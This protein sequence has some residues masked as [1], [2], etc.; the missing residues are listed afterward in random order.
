M[1]QRVTRA[2]RDRSLN[3][4]RLKGVLKK[5]CHFLISVIIAVALLACNVGVA[6]TFCGVFFPYDPA[7]RLSYAIGLVIFLAFDA[8]LIVVVCKLPD[9]GEGGY[10][11]ENDDD[12]DP[13]PDPSP[14]PGGVELETTRSTPPPPE[15]ISRGALRGIF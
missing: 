12:D 7:A 13:P 14:S 8:L 2:I 6:I 9:D 1:G 5:L 15:C 4:R 3:M 10:W 11:P